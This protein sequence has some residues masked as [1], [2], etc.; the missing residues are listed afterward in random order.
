MKNDLQMFEIKQKFIRCILQCYFIFS[1]EQEVLKITWL[2]MGFFY[3]I[4]RFG[5]FMIQVKYLENV[6]S[7]NNDNLN[8]EIFK[9]NCVTSQVLWE[10]GFFPKRSSWQK[11]IF[12]QI[13]NISQFF[14]LINLCT[15]CYFMGQKSRRKQDSEILEF[16]AL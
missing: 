13:H 7:F 10:E 4:C 16:F 9:E 14:S 2:I 5:N 6:Q 8:K 3:L 15:A 12:H 11:S 1:Q